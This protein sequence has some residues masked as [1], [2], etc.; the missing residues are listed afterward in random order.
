MDSGYI[1][2]ETHRQHPG[3]VRIVV[4]DRP[5]PAG[6][7]QTD[8]AL[9]RYAARFNDSAAALM[10][11]HEILKRRLI[12]VDTHLYRADEVLA[13]AAIESLGLSHR[14]VYIDPSIDEAT[15]QAI[16][17][18]RQKLMK[19]R[20]HRDQLFTTLGYA[21]IGILLFNLFVLSFR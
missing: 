3:I 21:G 14:D 13:I 10:H 7:S 1:G 18:A 15:K 20:K 19:Q 16:E 6:G 4:S 17:R 12:D 8:G 9:V 11:T 2:V 5:P